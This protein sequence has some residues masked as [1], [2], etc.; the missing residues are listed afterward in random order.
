MTLKFFM[1][2]QTETLEQNLVIGL[3]ISLVVKIL[4]AFGIL[5]EL[6]VVIMVLSALGLVTSKFLSEKRRYA[7]AGMAVVAA[8]VTPGDAITLTIFMMGP[9]LLLCEMSIGL[10][11]LVERRR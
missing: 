3:Y 5:F 4:L 6:P 11:E 9:L 2:F 1:S 7:I 8:F 10:A